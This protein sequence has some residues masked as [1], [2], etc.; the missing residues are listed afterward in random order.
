VSRPSSTLLGG[1]GPWREPGTEASRLRRALRCTPSL[2]ALPGCGGQGRGGGTATYSEPLGTRCKWSLVCGGDSV[3]R[4]GSGGGQGCWAWPKSPSRPHHLRG[5]LF[6][7]VILVG[8]AGFYGNTS[9]AA[10]WLGPWVLRPIHWCWWAL[11][12]QEGQPHL[13]SA[14]HGG[15]SWGFV[16]CPLPGSCVEGPGW[17]GW[18]QLEKGLG[19]LGVGRHNLPLSTQALRMPGQP[20][21]PLE[22]GRAGHA[23]N[24]G[25]PQG[26]SQTG[27]YSHRHHTPPLTGMETKPG[28]GLLMVLE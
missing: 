27:L 13:R 20:L 9:R 3:P 16:L 1:L 18:T 4:Q 5:L 2:G 25:P 26:Q 24:W 17:Q 15:R 6:V 10:C 7:P 12:P 23:V 19:S 21:C 28:R 22:R 14:S 11:L 8:A